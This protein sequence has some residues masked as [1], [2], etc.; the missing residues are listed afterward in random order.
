MSYVTF[1]GFAFLVLLGLLAGALVASAIIDR[2][3]EAMKADDPSRPADEIERELV[4]K[5]AEGLSVLS[6]VFPFLNL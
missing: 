4:T 5:Q 1:Y 2:Q 6:T 3:A